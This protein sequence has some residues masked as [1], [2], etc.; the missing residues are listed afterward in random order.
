MVRVEAPVE[1][2][3]LCRIAVVTTA[4]Y[5]DPSVRAIR[6]TQLARELP[7]FG[8]GVVDAPVVAD[9][10]EPFTIDG[11]FGPRG[12]RR[13]RSGAYR[14]IEEHVYRS[15][16]LVL[17]AIPLHAR[18][19]RLRFGDAR[20]RIKTLMMRVPS[21]LVDGTINPR[22][23]DDG[24]P[25]CGWSAPCREPRCCGWPRRCAPWRTVGCGCGWISSVLRRRRWT[26]SGLCLVIW[27]GSTVVCRI[28]RRSGSS[29]G[30]RCLRVGSAESV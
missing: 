26:R 11:R 24:L 27:C 25:R 14:S 12:L 13:L 4:C 16:D 10:E 20:E 3:G 9:V 5:P 15:S 21:L 2:V 6:W 18:W 8:Y 30:R 7:R 1:R 19:A 23:D 28:G 17:H 29:P 22:P